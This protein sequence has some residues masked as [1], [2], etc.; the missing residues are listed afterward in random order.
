VPSL[1]K[2]SGLLG[3]SATGSKTSFG[4]MTSIYSAAG[5]KGDYDITGDILLG[6]HFKNG[7][8]AVHVDR[9][10]GLAAADSNGLS[11]PYVKTYLLPDKSKNT[12]KKTE[13]KKKTLNPVYNQTIK[14]RK[15]KGSVFIYVYGGMYIRN[16]TMCVVFQFQMMRKHRSVLMNLLVCGFNLVSVH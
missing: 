11:D 1:A 12:K 10:Q 16:T 4:S 6:V 2:R 5:G 7:Q 13:I 3:L 14:V 15:E 8:L 9:A